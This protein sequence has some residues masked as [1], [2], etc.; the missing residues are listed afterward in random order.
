MSKRVIAR[1]VEST[2]A[3]RAAQASAARCFSA[4]STSQAPRPKEKSRDANLRHAINLYHLTDFFFPTNVKSEEGKEILDSAEYDKE[5]DSQ[6]RFSMMGA[7][8]TTS[9]RNNMDGY[10]E[11]RGAYPTLARKLKDDEVNFGSIYN[12]TA[13]ISSDAAV[14]ELQDSTRYS[15]ASTLENNP[16][17]SVDDHDA[18]EKFVAETARNSFAFNGLPE[19]RA[20]D[21]LDVRGAQVRDALFGTVGG[22]RPGL[23]AVR[24]RVK[25]KKALEERNKK[26]T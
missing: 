21:N 6:I 18:V 19:S 12:T 13:A 11:M 17:P 20:A 24:E 9:T 4:S 16:L 3:L 25:E 8:I 26:D 14:R 5:L 23:E 22:V 10:V 1:H 7:S 15:R 2:L